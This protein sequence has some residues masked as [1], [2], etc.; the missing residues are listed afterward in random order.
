MGND[1][2]RLSSFYTESG[3]PKRIRCY[4]YKGRKRSADYI[5]VVYTYGSRAV[6]LPKYTVLYRGMSGQPYH[7]LGFCQWGEASQCNFRPGGS[8]V[9]FSEL[10]QDCQDVVRNDY[11]Y[12]WDL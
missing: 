11:K 4:M 9:H 10:P 6:G 12:I 2:K 3:E 5:T 7:P 8:R 1:E